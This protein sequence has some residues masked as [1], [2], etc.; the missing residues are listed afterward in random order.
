MLLNK[1]VTVSGLVFLIPLRF[2]GCCQ[3]VVDYQPV[4]PSPRLSKYSYVLC[5]IFY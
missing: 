2:G 3:I 1:A 4:G 5:H